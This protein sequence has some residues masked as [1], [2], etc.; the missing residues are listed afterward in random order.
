MSPY[1]R[2]SYATDEASLE[3]ACKR[4]ATFVAGLR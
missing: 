2:I 1:V 4:I 3:E